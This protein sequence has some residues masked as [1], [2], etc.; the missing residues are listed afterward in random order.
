MYESGLPLCSDNEKSV[1]FT[2]LGMSAFKFKLD[3]S[4]ANFFKRFQIIFG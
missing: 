3:D 4:I 2:A 1:V